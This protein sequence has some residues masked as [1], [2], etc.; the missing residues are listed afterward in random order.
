MRKKYP[1]VSFGGANVFLVTPFPAAPTVGVGGDAERGLQYL[2]EM[3]K[4]DAKGKKK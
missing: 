3:A 1:Q 4:K 2:P